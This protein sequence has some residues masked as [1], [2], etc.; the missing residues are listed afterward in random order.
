MEIFCLSVF[1]PDF[2][3]GQY[4]KSRNERFCKTDRTVRGFI[5]QLIIALTEA[6]AARRKG[7]E[8]RRALKRKAGTDAGL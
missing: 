2:L 6:I 1:I 4:N 8:R 3:S 7:I 5:V